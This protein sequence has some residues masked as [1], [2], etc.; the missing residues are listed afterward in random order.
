MS[1]AGSIREEYFEYSSAAGHAEGCPKRDTDDW[2]VTIR[3]RAQYNR[4]DEVVVRLLCRT[5]GVVAYL[6]GGESS[7]H[8]ST[9][10]SG[11]GAPSEKCGPVW[12]HPGPCPAYH[13][14]PGPWEYFV[15]G[16]SQ[17][18]AD[19][20]EVIGYIGHCRTKR[21]AVRWQ[22]GYGYR[23]GGIERQAPD[24]FTS[25]RAAARW[26]T[27]QQQAAAAAGPHSAES[28]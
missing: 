4:P 12:L 28:P 13:L 19:E 16:S 21:G 24:L 8:T 11:Y 17:P 26:V 23:R 9:A 15:T 5:C 22:A 20:S 14:Q 2:E 27:E 10:R 6:E 1:R 18:P 25:K 3:R 7:E